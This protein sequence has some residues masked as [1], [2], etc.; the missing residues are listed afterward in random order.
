LSGQTRIHGII[1]GFHL[2]RADARRLDKTLAALSQMNPDWI[3]PCHCT[4]DRA[5]E[6][7][8]QGLGDRVRP[9]RAGMIL[10]L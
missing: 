1:G 8:L 9:G 2:L 10:E 7:L 5:V 4:G 6:H 3:I